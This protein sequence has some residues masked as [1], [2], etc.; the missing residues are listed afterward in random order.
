MNSDW[1]FENKKWK[2]DCHCYL[3][4]GIC[5]KN[6]RFDPCVHC[7]MHQRIYKKKS[8]EIFK[9]YEISSILSKQVKQQNPLNMTRTTGSNSI[10]FQANY[11]LS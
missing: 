8:D 11:C 3:C 4:G 2:N 1:D 5:G 9:L 6:N 10:T 7:E